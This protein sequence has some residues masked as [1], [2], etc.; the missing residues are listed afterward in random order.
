MMSDDLTRTFEQSFPEIEGYEILD[1][2]GYGGMGS[3]YEAIQLDTKRRVAIKLLSGH[4]SRKDGTARFRR[5]IELASQ[6]E[7][8]HIAR[9][10]DSGN[11]GGQF[12]YSMEFIDGKS[13]DEYVKEA[14]LPQQERL[15]LMQRICETIAYAH[16]CGIIH[17]DL[18]HAN[19]L[20]T[21]D[22]CPHILDFGLA[23]LLATV[24]GEALSVSGDVMGTPIFMSPEQASGKAGAIDARTDV[25]S[26]GVMLYHMVTGS[27]PHDPKG[28]QYEILRRVV[29]EEPRMPSAA[30]SAVDNEL[31]VILLKALA[32][33]P[34]QRYASAKE[35]ADDLRRYLAG[36]PITAMR[37]SSVYNFRKRLG[38]RRKSLY[39]LT[40]LMLPIVFLGVF[41]YR[42]TG[43]LGDEDWL[44]DRVRFVPSRPVGC[45]PVEIRYQRNRTP[46][47]HGPVFIHV[48]R[49]DWQ[50]VVLPNPT[51]R[52]TRRYWTY[53]Y[54]PPAGTYRINVAFTDGN[55]QWDN[56]SGDDWHV[57]IT[58]CGTPPAPLQQVVMDQAD[59]YEVEEWT[60]GQGV[61]HGWA[62]PWRLPHRQESGHFVG[63]MGDHEWL[64]LSPVAFGLWAGPN[65][66]ATASRSF[67]TPLKTGDTLHLG[68]QHHFIQTEPSQEVGMALQ[69]EAGNELIALTFKGGLEHGQYNI[70]DAEGVRQFGLH[71]S[72]RPHWISYH[73]TGPHSYVMEIGNRSVTGTY[74]GALTQIMFWNHNG[75]A[76]SDHDFF[77][78]QISVTRETAP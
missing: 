53:T 63:Q 71:W 3:V 78:N 7:H 22:G 32:R 56:N 16:G 4:L 51:M 13:V 65:A 62:G 12:Y 72:D 25:Y 6:L 9:V 8:P 67:A 47:G 2:I 52:E 28:S 34:E 21:D 36:D 29:H 60:D 43:N 45:R 15:Q 11:S 77:F 59:Y 20:V 19:I 44:Q 10:Y 1:L 69:D 35:L 49:N 42:N 50:D 46:L 41:A 33:E 66:L 54:Y 70:N 74:H 75:V 18:K 64:S 40:L 38:R 31:E 5:E 27:Y 57:D 17:R 58:E 73:I 61:G 48:G 30:N 14:H 68:M 26:L 55:D 76:G 39:A 37:P 24:D 23:K